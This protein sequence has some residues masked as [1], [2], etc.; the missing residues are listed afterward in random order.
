MSLFPL[1]GEGCGQFKEA[2][3]FVVE[4]VAADEDIANDEWGA[5]V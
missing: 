1:L 5:K 3:C 4:G 2:Q